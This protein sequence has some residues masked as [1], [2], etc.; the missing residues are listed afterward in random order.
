M[1]YLVKTN[2]LAFGGDLSPWALSLAN[3]SLKKLIE[4]RSNVPFIATHESG[5]ICFIVPAISADHLGITALYGLK[6]AALSPSQLAAAAIDNLTGKRWREFSR[7]F[8]RFELDKLGQPI[9]LDHNATIRCANELLRTYQGRTPS[10]AE[11]DAAL[12]TSLNPAA[13]DLHNSNEAVIR[14]L[15]H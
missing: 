7:G 6:R 2:P 10:L 5:A 13:A 14:A 15:H 1:A 9:G 11:I 12:S 8:V 4:A 3:W